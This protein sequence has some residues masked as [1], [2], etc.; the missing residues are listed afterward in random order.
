MAVAGFGLLLPPLTTVL[1]DAAA[2]QQVDAARWVLDLEAF[3]RGGPASGMMA[4]TTQAVSYLH[5]KE[6]VLFLA[7]P[8]LLPP[9]QALTLYVCDPGIRG[10]WEFRGFV[11]NS[12]PSAVLALNWADPNAG[13]APRQSGYAGAFGLMV[14]QPQQHRA[15]IG[16]AVEPLVEVESRS[17]ERLATK[18]DF[19]KRVGMDLYNYMASFSS[20]GGGGA[21]SGVSPSMTRSN[22]IGAGMDAAPRSASNVVTVPADCIDKWFS[23]FL[24]RFRRDPDF[25]SR[26]KA[27]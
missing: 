7:R 15:C 20:G 1:P 18:E 19:A 26:A 12:M 22:S 16:V 3:V 27:L 5:L 25:L 23:K 2:F 17:A 13:D 10:A 8:G 24:A 6:A 11:S 9:D 21:V 4:D 14:Q